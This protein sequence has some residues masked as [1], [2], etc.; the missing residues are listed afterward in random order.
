MTPKILQRL[1]QHRPTARWI[2]QQS[3]LPYLPLDIQVPTQAIMEEWHGVA[4]ESVAHRSQDHTMGQSHQGWRSLTL[5]GVSPTTTTASDLPHAW[6]EMAHRCPQT[7]DFLEREFQIGPDT[8]RIRFMLLAPGGHI[9]PHQDHATP[10]LTAV[11]I[12]I[13][14]PTGCEFRMMNHGVVPFRAGRAIM[15]DLS[16]RH[17]VTNPTQEPR[18]HIICHARVPDSTIE[19]SYANSRY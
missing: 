6:T 11:N 17:W 13:N 9:M 12:A 3:G 10:E 14:N 15:L 8:G 18:I 16:H 2:S 4:G 1:N 5:H 19:R 7:R